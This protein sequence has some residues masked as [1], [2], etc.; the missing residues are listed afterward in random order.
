M[1]DEEQIS[2][3]IGINFY[4]AFKYEEPTELPK[5]VKHYS[6]NDCIE[7]IKDGTFK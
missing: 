3:L 2:K 6:L 5:S 4:D 1:M 7:S